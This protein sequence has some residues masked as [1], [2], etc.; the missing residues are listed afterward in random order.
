MLLSSV[1]VLLEIRFF[2]EFR[3]GVFVWRDL[4]RIDGLLFWGLKS[5]LCKL[6]IIFKGRL[7]VLLTGRIFKFRIK[8][9]WSVPLVGF[10]V[11]FGLLYSLREVWVLN[12]FKL[13]IL[14]NWELFVVSFL[15]GFI[16]SRIQ[17]ANVLQKLISFVKTKFFRLISLFALVLNTCQFI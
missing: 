16:S 1:C 11:Y 15:V 10:G 9:A 13:W 2:F 8:F 7:F 6:V 4:E 3:I 5:D 14:L 12:G 17:I